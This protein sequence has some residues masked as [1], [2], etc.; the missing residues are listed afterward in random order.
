MKTF[1]HCFTVTLTGSMFYHNIDDIY[2]GGWGDNDI[3]GD[4]TKYFGY[5]QNIN[6]GG[7]SIIPSLHGKGTTWIYKYPNI[8][9]LHYQEFTLPTHEMF[10]TIDG[11]LGQVSGMSLSFMFKTTDENGVILFNEGNRRQLFA[12]ELFEG[13]VYVKVLFLFIEG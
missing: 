5:L 10:L 3:S 6:I 4:Y 9:H 12:V 7:Q 1:C 2:V 13:R 11:G 8:P